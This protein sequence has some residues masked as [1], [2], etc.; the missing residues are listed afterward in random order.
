[1]N[2]CKSRSAHRD[3]RYKMHQTRGEPVRF[4]KAVK[5]DYPN[6]CILYS[7]P[8][9]VIVNAW[10][11]HKKNFKADVADLDIGRLC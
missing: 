10:T 6:V 9:P 4:Q 3:Q 2:N 7:P 11:K 8:I 1:M 5:L